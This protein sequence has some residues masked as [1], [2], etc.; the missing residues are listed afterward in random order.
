MQF[1][2]RTIL[3]GITLVAI[4]LVVPSFVSRLIVQGVIWIIPAVLI[5]L[6]QHGSGT[7]RTAATG[8]LATYVA[9]VLA[10]GLRVNVSLLDALY[11]PTIVGISAWAAVVLRNRL[12][13]PAVQPPPA[14]NEVDIEEL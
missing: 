7:Q 14:P 8:A 3:I 12:G 9:I 10:G 5:T 13:V 4:G 1:S 2:L 11:V 6:I